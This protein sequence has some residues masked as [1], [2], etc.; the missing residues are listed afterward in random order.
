M[1]NIYKIS[2]YTLLLVVIAIAFS[3]CS[4]EDEPT[5]FSWSKLEVRFTKGHSHG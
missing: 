4:K 1:K 5:T 3:A 2:K